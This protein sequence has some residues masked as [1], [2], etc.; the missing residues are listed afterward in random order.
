MCRMIG[1]GWSADSSTEK[2]AEKGPQLCSRLDKILN[3][4]ENAVGNDFQRSLIEALA[5][6]G[7]EPAFVAGAVVS[8]DGKG[9]S[10]TFGK[11]GNRIARDFSCHEGRS[12]ETV[13]A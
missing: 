8:G 3:V 7:G 9:V 11:I 6:F 5:D 1:I 10:M 12:W 13:C 2:D 4:A